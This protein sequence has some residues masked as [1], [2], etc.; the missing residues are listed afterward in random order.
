MSKVTNKLLEPAFKFLNQ[1]R[2][3]SSEKSL[4]LSNA[5]VVL[6]CNSSH[7]LMIVKGKKV[8]VYT[9]A[10][11]TGVHGVM[12]G[13]NACA[14]EVVNVASMHG[15]IPKGSAAAFHDWYRQTSRDEAVE[16]ELKNL[17]ERARYLGYDLVKKEKK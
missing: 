6:S 4:R 3:A 16:S 11:N 8:F 12:A 14:P 15:F 13:W 5:T 2:H 10:E 9:R 17:S 1:V 7:A